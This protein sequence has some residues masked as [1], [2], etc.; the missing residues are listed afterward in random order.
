METDVPLVTLALS[1]LGMFNFG[2][3]PPMQFVVSC[4]QNYLTLADMETRWKPSRQIS[5]RVWV[6][7]LNNWRLLCLS[8]TSP[9]PVELD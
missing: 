2:C 7:S 9:H 8:H 3:H 5:N 1:S 4:A 6:L